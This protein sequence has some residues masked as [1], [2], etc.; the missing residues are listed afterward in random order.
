MG[1]RRKGGLAVAPATHTVVAPF[2]AS[3]D[4]RGSVELVVPRVG[5]GRHIRRGG[6][7]LNIAWRFTL[8]GGGADALVAADARAV[9]QRRII[10]SAAE[11][12]RRRWPLRSLP[13]QEP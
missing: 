12:V 2:A 8:G 13:R 11:M 3:D 5:V 6:V 10:G 1:Q 9:R 4:Q 7:E